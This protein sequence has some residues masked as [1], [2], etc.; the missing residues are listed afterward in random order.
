MK[1]VDNHREVM[2]TCLQGEREGGRVLGPFCKYL[3][4]EVHV[5]PF[6]VIPKSGA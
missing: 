6:G 5:S 2:E 3:M 4:P 1:S